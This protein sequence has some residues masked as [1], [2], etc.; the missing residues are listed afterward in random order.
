MT[1]AGTTYPKVPL[2]MFNLKRFISFS[3]LKD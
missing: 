1:M 3:G 2:A